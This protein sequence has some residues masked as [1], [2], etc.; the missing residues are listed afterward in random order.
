MCPALMGLAMAKVSRG[1]RRQFPL[2]NDRSGRNV[3]PVQR[4]FL[5]SDVARA[6][7]AAS[8]GRFP[9]HAYWVPLSRPTYLSS[10]RW[11]IFSRSKL[12]DAILVDPAI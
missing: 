9:A 8:V 1:G 4:R 2:A 7:S 5:S 10:V 12:S 3:A 6:H 11:R